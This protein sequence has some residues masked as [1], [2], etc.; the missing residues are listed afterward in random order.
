MIRQQK[1]PSRQV[2]SRGS[3]TAGAVAVPP[4]ALPSTGPANLLR[5]LWRH[6]AARF[7]AVAAFCTLGQL[8]VLAW[9]ARL[10]VSKV[11]ANGIGF[12]LAAQAN[13]VLS[14]HVTWRDRK[15]RPGRSARTGL[16]ASLSAWSARWARFN[17]VA[18]VALAVNE[19]VFTMGV[20]AGIQLFMASSAGIVTGAALT[21]TLNNLVTFRDE[22]MRKS[23]GAQ[24]ECRPSLEEISG[25]AQQDGVAFF[26]PAF[27]EAA[28]LRKIVPGIV[29]YFL[30]L[31]CPFTIIIVNDGSTE[32][33]TFETA[34]QL[35]RDYPGYVHAVHHSR[36]KGYGAALQTGFR[37]A[38]DTGHG[39]IGFCDADDQF[40]IASFGTLVAALVD[41]EADLAV[42]YRIARADSLK[43]RVMGRAWHWL[44]GLVLGAKTVRDVDCGFKV[45][46]RA[47]LNDVEP[48]I[49][50]RYA[51]VS[52][53]ILA[54]ATSAGYTMVEA[55]VTHRSRHH[56]RQTGSDL[57]VV[58]LSLTYLFHLRLTLR[59]ER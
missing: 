25:R 26:L 1:V 31:A 54:R 16:P 44:S 2:R 3:G 14:A 51:A 37:A 45:F 48:R 33:D 4:R 17:T 55:G 35:A 50:G 32:D 53:E 19:L 22:T 8:L 7:G 9:L 12:G 56:G 6:R 13:F 18:I 11:V 43:R 38:L 5:R 47:A 57:K 30:R 58:I 20:H 24:L 28:N 52:P 59:T 49:S 15:P 23:A 46:T 27:N 21:F 39:L 42:G 41:H 29:G 34:E 40:E 36:N 10:G